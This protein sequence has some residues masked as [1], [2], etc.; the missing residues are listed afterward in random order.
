MKHSDSMLSSVIVPVM[1]FHQDSYV[2]MTVINSS[3]YQFNKRALS[4]V[5]TSTSVVTGKHSV[6]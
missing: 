3:C 1:T 2:Y 6:C 4:K 5:L